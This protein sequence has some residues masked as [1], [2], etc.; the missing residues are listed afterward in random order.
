M[1]HVN[2]DKFTKNASLP[3]KRQSADP[4]VNELKDLIAKKT[5]SKFTALVMPSP[6]LYDLDILRKYNV[7]GKNIVVAENNSRLYKEIKRQPQASQVDMTDAAIDIEK[8]AFLQKDKFDWIN[9]DMCG[10]IS[11]SLYRI[12]SH[13]AKN[14]FV[15]D[16]F[17]WLTIK[18]AREGL[19]RRSEIDVLS[20][21]FTKVSNIANSTL[22]SKREMALRTIL[23]L[24]PMEFGWY[25][26]TWFCNLYREDRKEKDK[27]G[28]WM[29]CAGAVYT[30]LSQQCI[31]FDNLV[32][33]K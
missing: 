25:I 4:L 12:V 32:V 29:C 26:K 9:L 17:V 15:E 24:A 13:A 1:G 6:T 14:N 2:L 31:S 33:K 28:A 16:T 21:A 20:D 8:L 19:H 18:C 10:P 23:C 7:P 30:K 3:N 5:P 11:C 27:S 22:Q